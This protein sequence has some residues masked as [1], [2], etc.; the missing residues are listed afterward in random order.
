[1]VGVEAGAFV[2]VVFL[3]GCGKLEIAENVYGKDSFRVTM[4]LQQLNNQW[5]QD[6]LYQ[7]LSLAK[8]GIARK[9]LAESGH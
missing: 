4:V 5:H 2:R 3:L 8:N 9:P 7:D 1:M 6:I